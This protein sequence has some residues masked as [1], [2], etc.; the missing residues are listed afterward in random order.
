MSNVDNIIN[1]YLKSRVVTK[2]EMRPRGFDLHD[3]VDKLIKLQIKK[4]KREGMSNQKIISKFSK[5]IPF[6]VDEVDKEV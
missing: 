4:F 1:E 5:L 6:L 3:N 2:R